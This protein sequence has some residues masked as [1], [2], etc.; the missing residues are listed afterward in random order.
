[1]GSCNSSNRTSAA[2]AESFKQPFSSKQSKLNTKKS[3]LSKTV[4]F[5]VSNQTNNR[6]NKH[7]SS[8][9]NNNNQSS[10]I[11]K[12]TTATTTEYNHLPIIELNK[13]IQNTNSNEIEEYDNAVLDYFTNSLN[14]EHIIY[15]DEVSYPFPTVILDEN[16]T[17]S[18]QTSDII[19]LKTTIHSEFECSSFVN[20]MTTMSTQ[21]KQPTQQTSCTNSLN[22]F[23]SSSSSSFCAQNSK[24]MQTTTQNSKL[25]R[26]GFKPTIAVAVPQNSIKMTVKSEPNSICS[27]MP[28]SST[29]SFSR[30]ERAKSPLKSYLPR[31]PAPPSS[32]SLKSQPSIPISIS[33]SVSLSG[34]ANGPNQNISRTVST[35]GVSSTSNTKHNQSSSL[36]SLSS[37]TSSNL[38]NNLTDNNQKKMFK[39]TSPTKIATKIVSPVQVNTF[40]SSKIQQHIKPDAQNTTNSSNSKRRLFSPYSLNIPTASQTTTS[41]IQTVNLNQI[42]SNDYNNNKINTT[43]KVTTHIK[44]PTI[45]TSPH[46]H[47]F[48]IY[49]HLNSKKLTSQPSQLNS[50]KQSKMPVKSTSSIKLTQEQTINYSNHSP[51]KKELLN[52]SGLMKREDSAYC[53]STSSTVSSQETEINN[54]FPNSKIPIEEPDKAEEA[55][56]DLNE[57]TDSEFNHDE[58]EEDYTE[59]NLDNLKQTIMNLDLK[60]SSNML[61]LDQISELNF[62]L[63][64]D[65]NSVVSS[66]GNNR[67]RNRSSIRDSIGELSQLMT[68]SVSGVSNQLTNSASP[69]LTGTSLSEEASTASNKSSKQ[70]RTSSTSLGNNLTAVQQQQQPMFRPPSNLPPAENSEIIQID[71]DSFRLIMQDIQNTKIILYK[72]ANI[73]R[74]PQ[75]TASNSFNLNNSDN[76]F[77]TDDFKPDDLQSLMANNPLVSS[78]YNYV[79]EIS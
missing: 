40:S 23:E 61:N 47:Q 67:N 18:Q 13:T 42:Y 27:S 16:I 34:S 46:T 3:K 29:A 76:V 39:K 59:D 36:S 4:S 2:I 8:A 15:A 32:T 6:K 64:Q 11:L 51:I 68:M 33:N 31:P 72:L 79:S 21:A 25:N 45:V 22:T 77:N 74:E 57:E 1:M 52:G 55:P 66:S 43:S 50:N 28:S 41:A 30:Q 35:S 20:F 73:L 49:S 19:N 70:R 75:S 37:T 60:S 54:K 17:S 14:D 5:L 12:S 38:S 71:I 9:I 63:K 62:D 10:L 26:F 65:R 7:K 44:P 78:F 58:E 56:N 69:S 24:L 48:K 53:S